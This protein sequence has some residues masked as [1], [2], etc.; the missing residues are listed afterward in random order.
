MGIEPFNG[1]NVIQLEK[2]AISIRILPD[3]IIKYCKSLREQNVKDFTIIG[4]A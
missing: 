4:M 1:H 3:G 2:Y